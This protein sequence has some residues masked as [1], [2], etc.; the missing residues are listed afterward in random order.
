MLSLEGDEDST[1]VRGVPYEPVG[2]RMFALGIEAIANTIPEPRLS[3]FLRRC[4]CRRGGGGR[5]RG[6]IRRGY[7]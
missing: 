5:L 2:K 7:E 4:R 6:A 3:Q 1:P